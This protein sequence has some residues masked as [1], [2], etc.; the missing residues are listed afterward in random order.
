MLD[1]LPDGYQSDHV[2]AALAFVRQF[3]VAVD[4]GAHR[5]IITRQLLT[6]FPVVWAIEPGPLA[7]QIPK[8]AQVI[9]AAV[10]ETA[11]RCA[12]RDGNE[13][14]GQRHV[15]EGDDVYVITIDSLR[16]APDFIKIDVEGFEVFA[17]RGAESTIRTHHPVLLVEDN[18]LCRRYNVHE[19]ACRELLESWGAQAVQRM[20]IDT[21]Y[22]WPW[23]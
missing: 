1:D 10:G 14:T 6:H 7:R 9:R 22:A 4:V 19:G 16:L 2:D 20:G 17:L 8:E 15:V 18:G 13:N 5:G 11:G 12:M 23:R 21:V 3:R